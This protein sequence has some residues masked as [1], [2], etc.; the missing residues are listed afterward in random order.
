MPV[1]LEEEKMSIMN[2][3]RCER[4]VDTDWEEMH[5]TEDGKIICERCYAIYGDIEHSENYR[6]Q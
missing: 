3:D 5:E 1:F 2:C 6:I 4:P